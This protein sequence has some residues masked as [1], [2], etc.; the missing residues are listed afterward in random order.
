MTS[1]LLILLGVGFIAAGILLHFAG[2]ESA[3]QGLLKWVGKLPGDIRI[4]R[5]NFKF[6][7]PLVTCILASLVWMVV[8]KLIHWFQR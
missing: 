6:Y 2:G 4:E 8:S 1:R 5:E 3:M 7:F